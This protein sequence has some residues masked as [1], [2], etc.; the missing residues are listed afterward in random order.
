LQ[1]SP[2]RLEEFRQPLFAAASGLERE[3]VSH[4]EQ[5]E[6]VVLPAIRT[7][8]TAEEREAML[9]ELRARRS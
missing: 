3:F 7:L 4:L 1:S 9:P 6:K 8:A 2:E 5:E